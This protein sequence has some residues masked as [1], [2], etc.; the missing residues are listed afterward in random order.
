[1]SG[2]WVIRVDEASCTACG[3]C[4]AS[5]APGALA[6][7]SAHAVVAPDRCDGDGACVLGCPQGALALTPRGDAPAPRAA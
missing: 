4:L 3:N 1:M 5:C 2:E 7:G 6:L